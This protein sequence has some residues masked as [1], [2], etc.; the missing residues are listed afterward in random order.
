MKFNSRLSKVSVIDLLGWAKKRHA[1]MKKLT[2]SAAV[3]A[4]SHRRRKVSSDAVIKV[5]CVHAK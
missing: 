5:Q 1:K 3:K 4:V 2:N